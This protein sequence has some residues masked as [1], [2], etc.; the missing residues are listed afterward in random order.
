MEVSVTTNFDKLQKDLTAYGKR[1]DE[2]GI[3]QAATQ[4]STNSA[5]AIKRD[6]LKYLRQ[7]PRQGSKGGTVRTA[8]LRT[9]VHGVIKDKS[10]FGVG[11]NVVYARVHE[12]GIGP[13][14]IYPKATQAIAAAMLTGDYSSLQNIKIGAF[15]RSLAGYGRAKAQFARALRFQVGGKWVF[16]KKV[17]HPGQRARHWMSEPMYGE[18]RKWLDNLT[19]ELNKP[20]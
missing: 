20:L 17:R 11:S 1:L 2:R 19:T 7:N 4:L 14:M 10:T 9:S 6:F 12:K 3:K 8:H 5:N 13:Y 16:A 18:I 15:G